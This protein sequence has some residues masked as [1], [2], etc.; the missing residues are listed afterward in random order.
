MTDENS[1]IV[2]Y[3]IVPLTRDYGPYMR[4]YVW[5]EPD[6]A[7]AG[8]FI[9]D[10]AL[11]RAAALDKGRIARRDMLR[12]RVPQST[13]RQVRERLEAIQGHTGHGIHRTHGKHGLR[14]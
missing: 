10:V 9:R 13:A 5:A 14:G 6:V 7:Q 12:E 8:R 11:N 1:Y 2:D 4:G 3:R